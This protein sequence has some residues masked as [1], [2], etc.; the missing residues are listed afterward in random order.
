MR[1]ILFF[2]LISLWA[3]TTYAQLGDEAYSFLR[4]PSST[5]V[6]ALGGD[7]ISLVECDPSLGFHNP[8]LLGKVESELYELYFG[9]KYR[10]RYLY[11]GF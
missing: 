5:R 8:A 1:K 7:N 9:C 4:L 10:K 3:N 2:L 11:Q 6:G